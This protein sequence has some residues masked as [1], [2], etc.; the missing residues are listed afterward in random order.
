MKSCARISHAIQLFSY[1][2]QMSLA[3]SAHAAQRNV[4]ISKPYCPQ[5]RVH[6]PPTG[7]FLN[8]LFQPLIIMLKPCPYT[9]T[10]AGGDAADTASEEW[11]APSPAAS[12]SQ[13]S[14]TSAAGP[15]TRFDAR[16]ARGSGVENGRVPSAFGRSTA[17]SAAASSALNRSQEWGAALGGPTTG[18]SSRHWLT[19]GRRESSAESAEQTDLSKGNSESWEGLGGAVFLGRQRQAP[20]TFQ[21]PEALQGPAMVQDPSAPQE[22]DTSDAESF[23]WHEAEAAAAAH[24]DWETRAAPIEGDA[25]G[26]RS[27]TG[28]HTDLGASKAGAHLSE[29]S[30]LSDAADFRRSFSELDVTLDELG[31]LAA[32]MAADSRWLPMDAQPDDRGVEAGLLGGGGLEMAF[33][34]LT[35]AASWQCSSQMVRMSVE[36]SDALASIAEEPAR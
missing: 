10:S 12:L 9:G 15:D 36:L 28:M 18:G 27:L 29:A 25:A 8:P 6:L 30:E 26:E 34:P 3:R 19:M 31:L 4:S 32:P 21:G 1:I 20:L 2:C 33:E 13:W 16:S 7:L 23:Q 35:A 17:S 22:A 24:R 14:L 11:A 5:L